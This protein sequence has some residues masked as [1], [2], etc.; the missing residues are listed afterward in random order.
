[1]L[2]K[3]II[4]WNYQR[5]AF[6][7]DAHRQNVKR[8]IQAAINALDKDMDEHN[9]LQVDELD[10]PENFLAFCEA[11]QEALESL[12]R[13]L[14]DFQGAH[15]KDRYLY[16]WPQI[17]DFAHAIFKF[18]VRFSGRVRLLDIT[19]K[20]YALM[21]LDDEEVCRYMLTRFEDYF[22][23]E[24][25]IIGIQEKL[26]RIWNKCSVCIGSAPWCLYELC[27][28]YYFRLQFEEMSGE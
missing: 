26:C 11:N 1:M 4:N 20:S 18:G 14:K 2:M 21:A 22:E 7:P 25:D 8:L 3:K 27:K 24:D 10:E 28:S 12:G 19:S 16:Q 5:S 17:Q 23:G 6:A 13:F 9:V 15:D